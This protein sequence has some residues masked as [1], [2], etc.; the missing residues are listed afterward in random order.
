M[1]IN[2]NIGCININYEAVERII[3]RTNSFNV[4]R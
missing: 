3:F 4:K 1:D 2:K